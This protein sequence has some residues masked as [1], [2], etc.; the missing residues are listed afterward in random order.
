MSEKAKGV[1]PVTPKSKS[2]ETLDR[3]SKSNTGGDPYDRSRG[4]YSKEAPVKTDEADDVI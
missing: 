4:Q 3:W 2:R 1:P